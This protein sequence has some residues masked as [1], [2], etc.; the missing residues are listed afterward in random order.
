MQKEKNHSISKFVKEEDVLFPICPFN[1][2]FE[3][4]NINAEQCDYDPEL[5]T[6]G[7]GCKKR[8]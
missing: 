6:C 3:G 7:D 1:L 2:Y 4:D 8:K 5:K